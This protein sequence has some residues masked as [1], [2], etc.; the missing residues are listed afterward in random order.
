MILSVFLSVSAFFCFC[1]GVFFVLPEINDLICGLTADAA[2][3]LTRKMYMA[4]TNRQ[5]RTYLFTA[6]LLIVIFYRT[7]VTLSSTFVLRRCSH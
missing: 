5:L 7:L 6:R 4:K 2:K 3:L 1:M